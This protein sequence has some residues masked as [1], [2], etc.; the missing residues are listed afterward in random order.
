MAGRESGISLHFDDTFDA[1]V[2]VARSGRPTEPA[3]TRLPQRERGII[4][5]LVN[6]CSPGD[7]GVRSDQ[8]GT[9]WP[10]IGLRAANAG[11]MLPV[12]ATS[13]SSG[14]SARSRKTDRARYGESGELHWISRM[15]HRLIAPASHALD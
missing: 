7:V 4:D 3:G 6:R 8:Y 13:H 15:A 11:A 1:N 10:A 9:G 14:R 5:G 2:H 12:S